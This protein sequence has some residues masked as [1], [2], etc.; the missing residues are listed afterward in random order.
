MT[1]AFLSHPDFQLHLTG[2]NHPER[3]E[4]LI[5]IDRHLHDTGTWDTLLHLDFEAASEQDLER[6]HTP[7][8]IEHVRVIAE[9]G[10]GELDGDTVISPESYRVA[11]LA[12]GAAMRGVDAVMTGEANNAFCAVRPP[13][14]HAESGRSTDTPWGFCLFNNIAI[15]ARY[16]QEKYGLKRVA[17]LDFDVHHGNGTQEIFEADPSVLFVSLHEWGIF[18]HRGGETE[19]GVGEGVGATLNFPLPPN[20]DGAVY[21]LVWDRAGN[22]VREFKPELILVSAGFDAHIGD[23]LAHMA[24]K[25]HDYALLIMT[26]KHWASDMCQGRLVAVLEGGYNLGA[27]AESVEMVLRVMQAE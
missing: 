13:G 5:A 3:P 16:A 1:T 2:A 27:L 23:P 25:S 12:A 9:R 7:G 4:R 15:A 17:I 10:G 22:A 18:P 21:N 11:R 6:C 14:H 26:A 19:R 8:H 24:L 20:S